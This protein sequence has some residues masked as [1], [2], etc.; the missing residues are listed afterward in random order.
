MHLFLFLNKYSMNK[1]L[2]FS[3]L[4]ILTISAYAQSL[5]AEKQY[6][7][8][9]ISSGELNNQ[10]IA[11]LGVKWNTFIADYKYPELPIYKVTGEVD[12]TDV[13]AF[14][15]L[16]KKTI[17]QRCLQWMALNYQELAYHDAEAGKIIANGSVNLNHQAETKIGFGKKAIVP[18]QTSTNY[19][20]VLTFKDNK[21]KYNIV[22]IQYNFTNYS[23]TVVNEVLMP[24]SALF[25]IVAQ[26]QLHWEQFITVLNE[27]NKSL[28]VGLKKTI[29]DYVKGADAD[30]K[31]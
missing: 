29:A 23:L 30:Y 12:F 6:M 5:E 16:D 1:L 19:T 11:E 15:G 17:Y 14:E 2:L 24:F 3:V 20:L 8:M 21:M 31:F 7:N 28:G 22:N 26:D 18:A 10:Q 9:R 27:T 13:L 25:P 4:A